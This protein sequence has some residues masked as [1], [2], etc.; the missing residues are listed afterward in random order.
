MKK[1]TEKRERTEKSKDLRSRWPALPWFAG[2]RAMTSC[3]SDFVAKFN[4][5]SVGEKDWSK[6]WKSIRKYSI[7]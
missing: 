5:C 2:M 6:E 3:P 4:I 7:I 1:R